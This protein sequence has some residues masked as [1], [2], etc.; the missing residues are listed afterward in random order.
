MHARHAVAAAAA[1]AL[2]GCA[3]A[4]PAVPPAAPADASPPLLGSPFTDA[5]GSLGLPLV[6]DRTDLRIGTTVEFHRPPT[7]GEV[8]D[9][10]LV[11]GLQHVLI[12]LEHWPDSFEMLAPLE[13]VPPET[14][15]I[16]VLRGYPPSRAAA[17]AWNTLNAPLRL[18]VVVDGP[19]PDASV[20][21]DL[22]TMR[23]LERVVARMDEP[24]R[25]GF[26]RLQRPLSFLKVV[27]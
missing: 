10:G 26:E 22:N 27:Q 3:A 15:V 20:V 5:P 6:L 24:S 19:P 8:H 21:G 7:E 23:A 4:A 11:L 1:L 17:E 18:V 25:A 9:L 14:D 12:S 16:V 2:A 13:R